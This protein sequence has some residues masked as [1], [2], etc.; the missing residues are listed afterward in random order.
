MTKEQ[1]ARIF[2]PFERLGNAVTED[3]FGLGLAIVFDTVKLLKGSI[4]VE[5]E[6]LLQSA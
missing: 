4:A 1:Q 2:T 6:L 5:S 3:G